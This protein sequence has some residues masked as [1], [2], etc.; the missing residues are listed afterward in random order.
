MFLSEAEESRAWAAVEY[1]RRSRASAIGPAADRGV[2]KQQ[3][4]TAQFRSQIGPQPR[5]D[6][7]IA[8]RRLCRGIDEH[9]IARQRQQLR[10]RPPVGRAHR[11]QIGHV[12]VAWV[13][14]AGVDAGLEALEHNRG[15]GD[16]ADLEWRVA[17]VFTQPLDD[18]AVVLGL[19]IALDD[20]RVARPQQRG[21]GVV[22]DSV[23]GL[24][25]LLRP[26]AVAPANRVID[27]LFERIAIEQREL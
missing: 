4:W 20:T 2:R 16:A 17:I 5:K 9:V 8:E 22:K 7:W 1:R 12:G 3:A 13:A 14:L 26:G 25:D 24:A 11:L 18:R 19:E 27:M 21:E 10:R 15:A 23:A 6:G